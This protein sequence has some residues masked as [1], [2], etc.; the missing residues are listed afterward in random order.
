MQH[1]A[2]ARETAQ[3]AKV[4]IVYDA[5]AK[6]NSKNVSLNPS[7]LKPGLRYKI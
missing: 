3:T 7:V 4:R 2:E 5:S 1:K 6:N